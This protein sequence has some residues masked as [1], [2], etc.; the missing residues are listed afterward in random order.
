VPKLAAAGVALIGAVLVLAGGLRA[1]TFAPSPTTQAVLVSPRQPV[2]S[3][4][5]GL[6]GLEGPRVDVQAKA[7]TPGS[8]VFV[9]IGRARDVDAYL[10]QVSRLEAIGDNDD[11]SLVSK[12]L[13]SQPTLPDPAD[14]DVWVASARGPGA[15]DLVWSNPPGQWR[16][17][18][19]SDGTAAAASAITLTWSGRQHHTPAPALISIGLVL[20]VAGLITLVMLGSRSRLDRDQ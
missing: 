1:T 7:G 15:A 2:V 19:A 16:M 5:V 17:V 20:V 8:P 14:A 6:L 4:A 10:A 13:G 3:T 18:V 12:H 9:G 11:G